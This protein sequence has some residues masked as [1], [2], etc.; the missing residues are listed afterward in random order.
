MNHK[1]IRKTAAFSLIELMTVISIMAVLATVTFPV[2]KVAM[3][4]GQMTRSTSDARSIALGLRT[5]AAD[6]G[7][8]FPV[9]END[10]DEEIV[11]SND[12]FRSLLPDYIDSEQIF[13][14]SRSA[15][16]KAADNRFNEPADILQPGENHY[17]Y[18]AGL[19]DTSRTGW[20]LVVDG[21]NGSGYYVNDVGQKGGCW[22][23]RKAII[24]YVGGSA[25]AIRL[26]GE[27]DGDRFIPRDGYPGENALETG[28]MGE[29]ISLLEADE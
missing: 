11:S 19:S 6:N 1:L 2:V 4:N 18:V 13:V 7:G 8:M 25:A 16:G 20:P 5:Y 22:E 12:A 15:R 9:G 24:A 10:Y 14:Q 17:S 21:T 3:T 29:A 23:A 28:Y 26:R 27:R